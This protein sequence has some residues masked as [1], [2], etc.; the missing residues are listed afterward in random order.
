VGAKTSTNNTQAQ[1]DMPPEISPWMTSIAAAAVLAAGGA[2]GDATHIPVLA[3]GLVAIPGALATMLVSVRHKKLGTGATLY[4][5]G[6]WVGG[7]GWMA[8]VLAG[9]HNWMSVYAWATLGAGAV[10]AAILEPIANPE[11]QPEPAAQAGG[12]L[13]LYKGGRRGQEWE[14]RIYRVCNRLN[15]EVSDVVDWPTKTGY[16]VHALLPI[17]G[18]T[19]DDIK[20]ATKQLATDARLPRGCALRVVEGNLQGEVIISVPTVN[21]LRENI[22]FVA[23]HTPRSILKP[24][25]FPAEYQDGRAVE[26]M[27]RQASTLLV[28]MKGSGKTT[29]L[30][31]FTYLLGHCTDTLVWHIDLNGGGMSWAWMQPWI[32]GQTDR[33]PI[34]LTAT[35]PE[36]ALTMVTLAYAI[37]TDRKGS[38]NH[39]KIQQNTRLMP[40][41]RD[42]PAIQIV[43]DEGKTVLAADAR[44]IIGQIRNML[45]KIQDE[46]R[47][48]GIG[49]TASALRGTQNYVDPDFKSQTGVSIGMHTKTDA[50]LAYLFDWVGLKADDLPP[51]CG[52]I[53][54]DEGT[55]EMFKAAEI[56]PSDIAEGALHIANMRPELDAAGARLGGDWYASRYARM[57]ET[58]A[59][60]LDADG[61]PQPTTDPTVLEPTSVVTPMFGRPGHEPPR[62]A[63]SPAEWEDP[64]ARF[65]QPQQT[66]GRRPSEWVDPLAGFTQQT[67]GSVLTQTVVQAVPELLRQALAAFDRAGVERMHSETL[68]Q[69]LRIQSTNELRE[70]LGGLNVRTLAEA[71]I[72]G[73]ERRRGYARESLVDAAEKVALGQLAVPDAV[74]EWP[75]A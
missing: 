33:P 66:P 37:G 19:V 3:A 55:P 60:A 39:L 63:A 59:R 64:L 40:L 75:A 35:T 70:L 21:R 12:T 14:D 50:E 49:V 17:G 48:A 9:P 32:N 2:A 51:Y 65:N 68:A 6:C 27:L 46:L 26:L 71:F 24:L 22:P 4:R 74:A 69:A 67:A 36:D 72:V 31:L 54:F 10:A 62:Q 16:N 44:G 1:A 20:R 7:G 30:D 57:R 8:A 45:I 18:S 53:Q 56:R 25:R 15:V 43:V 11:T 29:L 52:Y 47:D 41:S 61:N 23:D 73:G 5:L 13:T 34:D 58:F 42:L 38:Y 28:G